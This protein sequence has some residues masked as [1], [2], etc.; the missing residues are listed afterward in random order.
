MD[1][2]IPGAVVRGVRRRES[3]VQIFVIG[4][5]NA[6][7][8]HTDD[9]DLLLWI[10]E[11]GCLLVTNNR[12]SMPDH[13]REHLATGHHIPGILVVPR[14]LS[15]GNLIEKLLLIWG[16]SFPGEYQDQIVYLTGI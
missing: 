2:H 14:R 12:S 9:P 4:Q 6:P 16:A 15:L 7:N 3:S 10:E 8:K 13:L 1:E 5:A 11:R